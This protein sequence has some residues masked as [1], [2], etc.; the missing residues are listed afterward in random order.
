M[1][2]AAN[3]D[4][5][6]YRKISQREFMC[7]GSVTDDKHSNA[8]FKGYYEQESQLVYFDERFM[9]EYNSTAANDPYD[10]K[11]YSVNIETSLDLLKQE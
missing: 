2:F 5:R 9:I 1:F 3:A 6:E 7:K 8:L 11:I 10:I 4:E